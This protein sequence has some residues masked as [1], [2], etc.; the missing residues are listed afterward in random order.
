MRL[1]GEQKLGV[2]R[3]RVWAALN[4]PEILR[5]CIPGCQSL[6][7]DSEDRFKATVAIKVGPIS[8]RFAGTVA[9]SDIDPLK[10][11]TIS[12]EGDGGA[13]G[14]AKGSARVH[15]AD[16]NGGTLLA[17]EVNAQVGGRL[18]QLGGPIID[19]TAKQLAAN[20]FSRFGKAVAPLA[21]EATPK[22]A[23]ATSGDP[24]AA[25]AT[26][27]WKSIPAASVLSV[28]LATIAAIFGLV[29]GRQNVRSAKEARKPK[30]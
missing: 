3:D 17:Y 25:R 14:F 24:T 18:A 13:S 7:R 15:L 1:N 27:F 20:F 9:L 30:S 26:A 4:D 29:L 6:E 12:G 28:I 19:A 11:Y 23:S 22:T 8:A 2:S 21:E 5:Q 10:G 16:E